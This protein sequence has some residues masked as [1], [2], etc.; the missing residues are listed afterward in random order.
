MKL[1]ELLQGIEIDHFRGPE[2]IEIDM[3]AYDSRQIKPGGLFVAM[4]GFKTDGHR[5]IS[6]AVQ[7]GARAIV[8]EEPVEL[9]NTV[10]CIQVQDSRRTMA[11]LATNW[12]RKSIRRLRLIGVTGTKGKTTTTWMI[13]SILTQAGRQTGLTGTIGN[14]FLDQKLKASHTTPESLDLQRLLADMQYKGVQD[15]VME[16]S[17]HALKLHRVDGLEFA[18]AVL[19]KIARDHLDFHPDVDDYVQSKRLLF[20]KLD[21][22]QRTVIFGQTPYPVFQIDGALYFGNDPTFAAH[23]E[24]VRLLPEGTQVTLVIRRKKLAMDSDDAADMWQ[25]KSFRDFQSNDEI[26]ISVRLPLPGNFNVLNALAA[27]GAAVLLGIAPEAIKAGLEQM[28]QVPGRFERVAVAAPFS[29]IVDYAH[30]PD[31]LEN[32]LQTAREFTAGKLWVVFGAGGDRDRGKRP[33]MGRAASDLADEVIITTDNPRTEAPANI[34]NEIVSGIP[35]NRLYRVIEDRREAIHTALRLAKSGDT[36]LIAGKGHEDYQ[37]VNGV[38]QPFYD[39][40]VV[41][42]YFATE[43]RLAQR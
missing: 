17:S 27:A 35:A 21:R 15:V 37:E 29:V 5:Y 20:D 39:P 23:C 12:Y 38:R 33:L 6:Q 24:D 19:T 8:V 14:F 9:P 31:A 10:A 34:I 43:T 41:K 13:R 36:V 1:Q 18:C 28:P 2:G 30:T 26:R 7:A 32:V 25:Q 22:Y 4:R 16:V 11:Q 3:L 40:L 42:E